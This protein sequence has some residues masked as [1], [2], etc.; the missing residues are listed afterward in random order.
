VQPARAGAHGT[1]GKDRRVGADNA[2]AVN[3]AV[4]GD[5]SKIADW[6]GRTFDYD[7]PF[8]VE[9]GRVADFCSMVEDPNPV[10]WDRELSITR[11]GA[12]IAPPATL[13][14]WRW[15][16][17]WTPRGIK[18]HSPS[19]APTVPLD[20]DTLINAGFSCR[21][22][23]QIAICD[24]LRYCEKI[25]SI[26]EAKST[27]L[28]VGHFIRTSLKV[29]NQHGAPVA[30]CGNSMFRYLKGSPTA[31]ARAKAETSA[32]APPPNEMP[33]L[34]I[35]VTPT[36]IA[37]EA[38]ATRDYF[39][40]H[41]DGAYAR[42]QGV[43]DS[44]PNTAYYCGLMDRVA[45]E[46]A[47]F[48]GEVVQRELTMMTPAPIGQILHTRGHV[49]GRTEDDGRRLATLEISVVTEAALIARA[50]VTLRLF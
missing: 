35:P 18:V 47:N 45:T 34:A 9:A 1:T 42:D 31:P 12:Q 25:D 44:Y 37:L 40:G 39:P 32:A 29:L 43:A 41:H 46:W 49:T 5:G 17:P 48:E 26:S 33:D 21:F 50:A 10:Y 23:G 24:R 4:R 6:V 30:T 11:Y 38:A 19:L 3:F 14:I 8:P 28:G 22:S 13:T 36:L 7:A 15:S 2:S 20:A 16:S 27:A